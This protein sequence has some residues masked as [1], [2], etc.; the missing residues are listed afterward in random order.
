M[1][2][3]TKALARQW[4]DAV[5]RHTNIPRDAIGLLG[6]GKNDALSAHRV[7]IAVINTAAARLPKIVAALSSPV[8]L[9][10]D[11][12]HRAGADMFQRVLTTPA[13]YTL[14]LSATPERDEF[15]DQGE[16]LR[17]DEQAVARSLGSLVFRFGLKEARE[18]GWLP[19][20]EIH[21]HGVRLDESER[22]RYEDLTRQVDDAK[23]RLE[24]LGQETRR[25]RQLSARN[26]DVGKLA[27]S[28]VAVTGKRK[29][30]LYRAK[31]RNDVA[32]RLVREA[33]EESTRRRIILF[34][35]RV[36]EAVN[37]YEKIAASMPRDL[38]ALEHSKLS[39]RERQ[40]GIA[41]FRSG[42][43]RVMVS[44]KSLVEG[45]DVPEADVGISVASSASVRQRIQSLGRVLRRSFDKDAAPKNAMMHVI[46]VTDTVDE[47]IYAKE[48]W[49]DITGPANNVYWRWSGDEKAREAG[50]PR[51]PQPSEESV[52]EIFGRAM[53]VLPA[54]WPGSLGGQEYSVDTL[55]NVTNATGTSIS[56]PQG[57]GE[58]VKTV[59]GR[60]GGRFR[61]TPKYQLVI[62]S[63]SDGSYSKWFLAGRLEAPFSGPTAAEVGVPPKDASDR[64]YS[65]GEALNRNVD[66][67]HGTFMLRQKSGGVIEKRVGR[68]IEWALAGESA[69]IE[70]AKNAQRV[71]D[72]WRT[73][74]I[75]GLKMFVSSDDV[76]WYRSDGQAR[77]L[78]HVPG[79]FAWPSPVGEEKEK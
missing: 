23:K 68:S 55:G 7:L 9:V 62:V 41:R 48:D 50:P 33:Q 19:R 78:A 43:A 69:P 5:A 16:P 30:V 67:A 8:M 18:S 52:W 53:P 74:G 65:A 32:S 39:D 12:C 24:G 28:Y 34:H 77:F 46:Y 60:P 66:V 29:D 11:E 14:G 4:V 47:Q 27:R 76:A 71:I 72:A 63:R 45:I 26:D 64:R 59:R 36:S 10:V 54:E 57:V 31:A 35:E 3:P 20:Y 13:K 56:N 49:S 37:L 42:E 6:A 44:V 79:G 40:L 17:Y 1:V 15:D 22:R 70:L 51:E 61:V 38:L 21:H 2:V 73:L 58:M 25:A 75:Q